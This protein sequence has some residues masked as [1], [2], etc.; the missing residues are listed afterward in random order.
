MKMKGSL[1]AWMVGILFFTVSCGKPK[2]SASGYNQKTDSL[3]LGVSMGMEKKAFYDYCWEMN[4]QKV[5][6]HGPTNQ[7]VEY[8]LANELDHP[9]FMEFYP[10]FHNDKIYEVPVLFKY[11]AWAP[12]NK[13]YSAD[14]L[15]PKIL[16]LFKK[17]YGEDFQRLDHPTQGVVYYQM[18]G[19]RRIN[20]FVRDDQYVHAVFTD[21]KV[22]KEI[23]EAEKNAARE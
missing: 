19:K 4:R 23:R 15:F 17:W 10:S 11:E 3:F 14:A 1:I 22:E 20:L 5:F 9:V 13:E 7:S 18:K 12:W 21:L 2:N 16:P 6:T 8:R